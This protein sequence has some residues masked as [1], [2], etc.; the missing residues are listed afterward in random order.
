M[1]GS[2][3]ISIQLKVYVLFESSHLLFCGASFQ[4][5]GLPPGVSAHSPGIRPGCGQSTADLDSFHNTFS[6]MQASASASPQRD[7]QLGPCWLAW[8][9][10][11]TDQQREKKMALSTML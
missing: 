5:P 8:T 2:E 10:I 1:F 3:L 6:C 11:T 9:T 7:M 4:F